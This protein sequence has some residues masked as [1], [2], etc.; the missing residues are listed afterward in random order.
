MK[1]NIALFLLFLIIVSFA[2]VSVYAEDEIIYKTVEVSRLPKTYTRTVAEEYA[3]P[4]GLRG[5][6]ALRASSTPSNEAIFAERIVT[7]WENLAESINVF[8]LRID[9][10]PATETIDSTYESIY[11]RVF[12]ENPRL[13]YVVAGF[14]FSYNSRNNKI[15]SIYPQYNE[16][17][18]I[19]PN[20]NEPEIDYNKVTET[21][22]AIDEETE[23]IL[24][25][26]NGNMSD[27]DKVMTVHDYI[28]LNY[29]YDGT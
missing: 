17:I 9:Y 7:G 24:L 20:A 1:K 16:S 19:D 28:A 21:L 12:Y 6:K 22:A 27:F 26:I 18:Y 25:H 14:G 29:E 3:A 15:I 8:D 5:T 10:Y 13:Y 23:N 4:A 11:E 2:S